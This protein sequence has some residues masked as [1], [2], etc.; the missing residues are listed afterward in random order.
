MNT[1]LK[2][3]DALINGANSQQTYPPTD[4][5]DKAQPGKVAGLIVG[6]GLAK[7]RGL[8][9]CVIGGHGKIL[10]I[11]GPEHDNASKQDAERI[12]ALWNLAKDV[13]TS[14]LRERLPA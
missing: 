9:H 1:L 7:F 14:A 12:A 3:A 6:E 10:C 8:H 4:I 13:P 11:T 5:T 2:F